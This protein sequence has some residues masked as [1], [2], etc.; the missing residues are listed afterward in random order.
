MSTDTIATIAVA[1]W[2]IAIIAA[3]VINRVRSHRERRLAAAVDSTIA[4]LRQ[5]AENRQAFDPSTIP[6]YADSRPW[7]S[8]HLFNPRAPLPTRDDMSRVVVPEPALAF[9][10]PACDLKRAPLLNN[11]PV[12]CDYCGTFAVAWGSRVYFW[13][14]PVE[15]EIW[16]P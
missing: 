5:G 11:T 10:C 8:A 6:D 4:A 16:Q 15:A 3:A 13:C 9:Q 1:V 7:E 2:I 12:K 14:E